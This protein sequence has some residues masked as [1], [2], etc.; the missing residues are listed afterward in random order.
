MTMKSFFSVD[1]LMALRL[2]TV[3]QKVDVTVCIWSNM[4]SAVNALAMLIAYKV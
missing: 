2:F 1:F 3:K 4:P